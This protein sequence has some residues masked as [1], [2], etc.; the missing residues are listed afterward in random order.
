MVRGPIRVINPVRDYHAA[1]RRCSRSERHEK[2]CFGAGQRGGKFRLPLH[3]E[4]TH[5]GAILP[6]P[7]SF[8]P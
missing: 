5:V 4:L 2:S 1:P 7:L 8:H 3:E 6:G